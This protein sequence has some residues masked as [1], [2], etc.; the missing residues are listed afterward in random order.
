MPLKFFMLLF[1]A[2][3]YRVFGI[4]AQ[5]GRRHSKN[6]LNN[7]LI[8][9]TSIIFFVT[10]DPRTLASSALY[11]KTCR[12][13]SGGAHSQQHSVDRI[14]LSVHHAFWHSALYFEAMLIFLKFLSR[15]ITGLQWIFQHFRNGLII[16]KLNCT[17]YLKF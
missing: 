11:S 2:W 16:S 8:S 1:Y 14:A 9:I 4:C 6:N 5:Y 12:D 7:I 17:Q 3:I 13:V 10:E 15:V